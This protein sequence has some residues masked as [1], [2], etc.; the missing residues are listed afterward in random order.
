[1]DKCRSGFQDK[2]QIVIAAGLV[3]LLTALV[4][5][6]LWYSSCSVET[7]YT[8]E[9]AGF[10]V[11]SGFYT[12]KVKLEL[13]ADGPGSIYYTLDGSEPALGNVS[14][15]FYTP[16]DT[17]ELACGKKET[18][19]TVRTIF[20]PDELPEGS[21]PAVNSATYIIGE[22]VKERYDIPVLSV[23]G[24]PTD[25]TD[26]ESGILAMGNREL[27]GAETEQPVW[28]TLFD[29]SGA[30]M[31]AQNGGVRVHGG[32]SRVKNQPSMRL[33]ARSEYDSQNEFACFLFDS[34]S[35]HNTLMTDLKRV[36]VR[37]SG[38]DNG[39]AHIRSEY[40]SKLASDAGFADAQASSPVCVYVNGE[41]YGVYWFLTNYD[42]SYF[43]KKYG[44]NTGEM[45][46]LEGVVSLMP[47]IETDDEI[48]LQLKEEYN[49]LHE[50][51]AYADLKDDTNWQA[52]NAAID[53]ENFLQYV[54]WQNYL[55]NADAFVNNFKAYR[56]YSPTGEYQDGTVFDGRYRFLLYDLDETLGF[57]IYDEIA[58]EARTQ[59]VSNRVEYDIYYNALFRN[60]LTRPEGRDYYIRYYLS[61]INYHCAPGRVLPVLD[62]MH[63]SHEKELQYVYNNTNLMAGNTDMPEGADYSQVTKEVGEIE[64]YILERPEWAKVDLE[65]A[66]GISHRYALEVDNPGEAYI[67]VD[68]AGFHDTHYAGQYY[69]DVP[70][71]V[72]ATPKC[73][74][75]FEYWLIDGVEYYD[76]LLV[77]T[78]DMIQDDVLYMECVTSR[79]EDA[80][81]YVSA[82]RSRGGNDY[83]ELT[84]YGTNP[85]DLSEYMLADGEQQ[86]NASTLPSIIVGAGET[87]TVYCKN[88]SGAESIGKP[89]AGFNLKEGETLYLYR[90]NLLQKVYIPRMG[91]EDGVYR[92]D[93][94][95]SAFYETTTVLE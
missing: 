4:L 67:E 42:A 31:F 2:R 84:N 21:V 63:K 58:A 66:F 65:S 85:A 7:V 20:V 56:Y 52:L 68:F 45:I 44:E 77:I 51:V 55:G 23:A 57:G 32:A 37:N 10:S 34:Y 8:A 86:A 89:E 6:S 22:N 72:S 61:L 36:I 88:Y 18:V 94:Y 28:M 48:T 82:V 29:K 39:Y 90:D 3:V 17:I 71:T 59:I 47:P 14:T 27:R 19:Y 79:D 60:I 16:G 26:E 1:M 75:K 73:G 62:K 13:Y 33:Y 87:V 30:I 25:L 92:M 46:V 95:S 83:I 81:L 49:A 11:P 78:S 12:K 50:Y 69:A 38:D 41:Y 43:E 15:L 9:P 35:A 74:D 53:V 76:N 64:N 80:G 5:F 40:A 91:T 70:V 93:I 54:A 24:S